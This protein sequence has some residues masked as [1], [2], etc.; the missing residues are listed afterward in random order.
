MF[1][2][3]ASFKNLYNA[4]LAITAILTPQKGIYSIW[5]ASVLEMLFSDFTAREERYVIPCR[6]HTS[7]LHKASSLQ[8]EMKVKPS[9]GLKW[10]RTGPLVCKANY[11]RA[12]EAEEK[13]LPP[14]TKLGIFIYTVLFRQQV[15]ID[16]LTDRVFPAQDMSNS[17]WLCLEVTD[18]LEKGNR[19]PNVLAGIRAKHFLKML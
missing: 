12:T 2:Y 15:L 3:A 13:H 18:I 4:H 9:T 5:K 6:S 16:W 10:C 11:G 8:N 17:Y 14:L 19:A 7:L 1:G